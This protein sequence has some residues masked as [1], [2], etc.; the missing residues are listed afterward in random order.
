M[1]QEI[2]QQER[3]LAEREAVLIQREKMAISEEISD[4]LK[5]EL[6]QK[7]LQRYRIS[8]ENVCS[9]VDD[10]NNAKA[11]KRKGKLPKTEVNNNIYNEFNHSRKDQFYHE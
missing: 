9:S 4:F 7:S 11:G 3:L 10:C 8:M 6:G 5:S 1:R 2:R